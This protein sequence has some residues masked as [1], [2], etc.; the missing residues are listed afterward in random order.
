[1]LKRVLSPGEVCSGNGSIERL[2]CLEPARVLVVTGSSA[3]RGGTLDR[4]VAQLKD[5]TAREVIEL[6]G[7][8]PRAA[9][10]GAAGE[11]VAA[12]A[13]EWIVAVGGGAVLDTA[14]FLWA[15]YEYPGLEFSST[16][17]IGPL[18]SKARFV[19]VP[20]TAGSGSEASQ[21]A[22]L[23]ADDG[24]KVPCVSPHW[25]PDIAIL[26]P[27]LTVSLPPETTVA[28][29]FDALTHAVES[30]VSSLS[31]P[32]LHALSATAVGLVLRHLPAAV[33]KPG[34]LVAREGMLN[35]AY[36]GGLCQSTASTGAAHALSH[37]TAKLHGASHGSATGFYLLPTMRWN[38][39][40]NAAVYDPLSVA[41]GFR[42]GAALVKAL[43]E[44]ADRVGQPQSFSALVGREPDAAERQAL[45]DTAVKDICLRTNACRL[46]APELAALLEGIA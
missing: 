21:A 36:L 39:N 46:G 24:T 37:A 3:R 32:M 42:D 16:T 4:I 11:Q 22:V 26:D 23:S 1:M 41:C 8:E 27:K 25:L 34:D 7:G 15:R 18:R 6:G 20:T 5:A 31:N 10:I 9:V 30:A 13:P 45:A 19:A 40:K 17:T 12:F 29:G 28:T 14:K 38:R 2:A 35:A 43:A 44:L 33:E